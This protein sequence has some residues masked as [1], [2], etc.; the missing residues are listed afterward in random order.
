[1]GVKKCHPT[2]LSDLPDVDAISE[3]LIVDVLVAKIACSEAY[4]PNL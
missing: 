4:F 3:I 1:M 2:T